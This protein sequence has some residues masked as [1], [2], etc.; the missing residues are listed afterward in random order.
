MLN[1]RDSQSKYDPK[2][3]ELTF[4]TEKSPIYN[5]DGQHRQLGY[6]FR[7]EAEES[8]G[9]FPV[10]VVLTRGM[11]KLTEMLQFRTINS[12]AKGVATALVNAILAKLQA[13]EGDDA[14]DASAQRSVTC[15]KATEALSTE[16]DSPWHSLIALPNQSQWTKKEIAEDPSREHERVIKANSF[17]DA[18]RPVFDY[19]S[20]LRIAA[21]IDEKAAQ[22][23]SIVSEFWA[24]L[25]ERMPEA[26][27]SASEYSLFNSGGVG[28][29]H[30]V[31]RDLMIKMHE[32]HRKF[33]KQEFLT[34]MEGS[35]LLRN[36]EFWKSDNEDGARIYSGKANWPDLAKKIIRDIEDGAAV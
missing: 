19:V 11:A 12:T 14:I 18:L 16:P 1:D 2:K 8:F 33:V 10:P 21:S 27:E 4:D 31:L 3:G 22:I 23:V 28:P 7:F 25:K 15:Y 6:E 30:L 32:G 24:A 5:Y 35:D 36:P 17:V 34:M 13:I 26:F 29:M 20:M 9:E